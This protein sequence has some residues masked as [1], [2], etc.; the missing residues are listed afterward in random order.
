MSITPISPAQWVALTTFTDE[1]SGRL[2]EAGGVYLHNRAVFYGEFARPLEPGERLVECDA[3]HQRFADA[4]GIDA[5]HHH[6]MHVFGD[7]E[8]PT[9]CPAAPGQRANAAPEPAAGDQADMAQETRARVAQSHAWL[10]EVAMHDAGW[11][12]LA[13][14]LYQIHAEIVRR[15]ANIEEREADARAVEL[16]PDQHVAH[17]GT[18][19]FQKNDRGEMTL[20]VVGGASPERPQ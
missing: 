3:C 18:I 10:A 1:A 6:A 20:Q 4:D 12:D 9:I 19:Q 15:V 16:D 13:D 11:D 2:F 14:Q 7:D 8:I 17:L 5:D